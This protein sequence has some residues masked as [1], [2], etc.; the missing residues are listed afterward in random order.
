M[1]LLR[2]MRIS[3][4]INGM[5]VSWEKDKNEKDNEKEWSTMQA[6][7]SDIAGITLNNG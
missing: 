6:E 1:S 3:K 7:Y 4:A 2:Q 5:S